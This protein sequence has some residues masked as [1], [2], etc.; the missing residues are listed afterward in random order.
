MIRVNI[1]AR[2]VS[3]ALLLVSQL[4]ELKVTKLQL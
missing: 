1:P 2:M 4:E 3:F